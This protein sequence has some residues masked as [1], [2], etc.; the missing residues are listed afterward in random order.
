VGLFVLVAVLAIVAAY[1]WVKLAE[2]A[3]NEQPA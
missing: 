1:V 3:A 2:L